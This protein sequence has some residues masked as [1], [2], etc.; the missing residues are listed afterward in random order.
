MSKRISLWR[1]IVTTPEQGNSTPAPEASEPAREST[2]EAG[3]W[4]APEPAPEPAKDPPRDR[5]KGKRRYKRVPAEKVRRSAMSIAVSVEEERLLRQHA[6][7]LDRS[8]SEWARAVLFRAMG[9]KP[10]ARGTR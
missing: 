10:P 6:E 3:E 1:P 5:R 4:E 8:F 7:S 2:L 9:R